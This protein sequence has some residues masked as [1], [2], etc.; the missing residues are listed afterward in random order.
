MSLT[1]TYDPDLQSPASYGH[2]L[3]TC[4]SSRSAISRFRRYSGNKL[5]DGQ[6]DVS[7]CITSL[8]N[9]VG[10]NNG[11]TIPYQQWSAMSLDINIFWYI[12][13]FND[14]VI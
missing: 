9:V 13:L 1:L 7:D 4:K 12:V 5:T 3:L 8:A 2:N 14:G 6:M 10:K 11:D